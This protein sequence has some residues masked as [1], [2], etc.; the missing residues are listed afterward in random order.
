MSMKKITLELQ[1]SLDKELSLMKNDFYYQ[2]IEVNRAGKRNIVRLDVSF[3]PIGILGGDTY[4]IRKTVDGKVIFFILDA[5]G[6]GISASITA[7]TSAT[8]LN[9]IF[10]DMTAHG[11]FKFKRWINRYIDF[12]KNEILENEMLAVS[13]G[14]YNKKKGFFKQ[15]SFG[16]PVL[17]MQT[18]DEEF[19]KV[20]S[21]NAPISR[22]TDDFVIEKI[23]VKNI[24]KA[25]FYTDGLCESVIEDG[26]FYRDKMYKDFI[27]SKSIID[28][29]TRVKENIA[30]RDD[31][32]LYLYIDSLEH[33]SDFIVK[34]VKP[35]MEDIDSIVFE[36]SD[37]VKNSGAKPKEISELSL[38]L[39][40]LM[41]NALE[42]G[43]FGLDKNTK[44]R[45][46]NDGKFD[47][48][49]AEYEKKYKDREIIVKYI[50]KE[51]GGSKILVA[52]IEDGG[53]GFDT[54]S[55][56]NLVISSEYFNGRG[57]LII[58]KLLDRFYYNEKGN[59][60]TIRK[61]LS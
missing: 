60:I 6:K 53:E 11:N 10:D 40:E 38:A 5:M 20:K 9:Y 22:Y 21:N 19:I 61:F 44:N 14:Y 55:L 43:V 59:A 48:A 12:V 37:Y 35:N 36:I 25:L 16:M 50:V 45:L 54:K 26:K 7:A 27:D 3:N 51:E 30:Q 13:F 42:H 57:V 28:F 49:L 17:L 1:N 47:I 2:Q 56:R 23:D 32:I 24:K 18:F 34:H 8:L 41:A 4:S 52:R 58:K 15:A 39:S 46:I 33:N 31:D 29:N